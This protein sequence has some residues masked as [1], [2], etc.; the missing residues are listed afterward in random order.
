MED[1]EP[2]R[3]FPVVVGRM[4]WLMENDSAATWRFGGQ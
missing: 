4:K 2:D 1:G 3:L